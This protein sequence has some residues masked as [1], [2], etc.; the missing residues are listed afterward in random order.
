MPTEPEKPGREA[1]NRLVSLVA[2]ATL[3]GLLALFLIGRL[4]EPSDSDPAALIRRLQWMIAILFVLAAPIIVFCVHLWR[5]GRDAVAAGCFP[6]PDTTLL[7]DARVYEGA[8]A[9]WRGRLLQWVALVVAV[10]AAALP[11]AIWYFVWRVTTGG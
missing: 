11:C 5:L 8:G 7:G 2:L 9:R 3:L 1:R 4:P 10:S 6:P